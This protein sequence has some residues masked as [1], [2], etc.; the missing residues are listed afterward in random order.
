[1]PK[2]KPNETK[3]EFIKRC[4][5]YI[6][7]EGTEPDQASAICYSLWDKHNKVK[8]MK[9]MIDEIDALYNKLMK[10]EE[11]HTHMDIYGSMEVISKSKRKIIA[12]YASLAVVD[13]EN[14]FISLEALKMGLDTLMK[15]ESYSNIMIVHQNVQIG[16]ILKSYKDLK[17]HVDEKGLFVVAEIRDDLEIAKQTWERILSGE[18][19]GF[20]I[21]GEIIDEHKVCDEDGC[22]NIIDKINLF[23][24]SVCSSPINQD[25]KFIV[26]N[27]CNVENVIKDFNNDIEDEEDDYEE[28]DDDEDEEIEEEEEI[29]KSKYYSITRDEIQNTIKSSIINTIKSLN[30]KEG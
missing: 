2:P 30:I 1:M 4:I 15:D 26:V 14:E 25:S 29:E 7:K 3:D 23:E 22:V 6:I 20:S 9:Q 19:N 24:I 5:P 12:G 16:K 28:E 13:T 18:L 10:S 21:G 11:S 8:S 17:T 27:K